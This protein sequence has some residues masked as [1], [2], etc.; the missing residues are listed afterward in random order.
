MKKFW[1]LFMVLTTVLSVFS[2]NISVSIYPYY[3]AVREIAGEND[4]VNLIIP[5]GKSPHTYAL[6]VENMKNLYESDILIVNG[7]DVE[8]FIEKV[9]V[10]LQQKKIPVLYVAQ[11]IKQDEL[12]VEEEEDHDE[13]S[14]DH[15]ENGHVHSGVN[16]HVWTSPYLMYNYMI[17]AITAELSK[18]NPKSKTLYEAN[19]Q[20][21]IQKVKAQ[22]QQFLSSSKELNISFFTFHNS[23]PYFAQRY[24]FKIAGVVQLSPG[25]DPTPSQMKDIIDKAKAENAN[26]IFI[27][28][29]LSDRAAKA[30]AASAGLKIGMLDPL[31]NSSMKTITD[32][33]QYNFDQIMKLK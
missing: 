3:L 30:I 1:I 17:P 13:E 20:K 23:F 5:Q 6:T 12:S 9:L 25:I 27:E 7:L 18:V 31:G 33:Y 24:G 15:K 19:A 11:S 4:N 14:E 10:S 28:P 21:L 16:P 22:D 2:I 26:V 8:V 29:Q 32:L